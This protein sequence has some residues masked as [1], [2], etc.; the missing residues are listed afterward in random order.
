MERLILPRP[1]S[2]DDFQVIV[3]EM[4]EQWRQ[5]AHFDNEE[6]VFPSDE[7]LD[8]LQIHD[9]WPRDVV[10]RALRNF[11]TNFNELLLQYGVHDWFLYQGYRSVN[12]KGESAIFY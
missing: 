11:A 4:F 7:L 1:V 12:V 10:T 8:R 2:H 6:A 5:V 3:R 9:S